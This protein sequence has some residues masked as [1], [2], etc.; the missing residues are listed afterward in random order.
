MS[1]SM[2]A[3]DSSPLNPTPMP[4]TATVTEEVET[5]TYQHDDETDTQNHNIIPAADLP[6]M[7]LT[8]TQSPKEE[9][10][11]LSSMTVLKEAEI[12]DEYEN[13]ERLSSSPNPNPNPNPNLNQIN[14]EVII[15]E[16]HNIT[17][18]TED[19]TRQII[20]A[21]QHGDIKV[22]KY[23]LEASK[24]NFHPF[25]PNTTDGDGI[26]LVHWAALN[27]KLSTMKYLVSIGA[28][29]DIPAGD[30]NATPLLWAARYGL[31]Y[32]ADWL[33]REGGADI[34]VVDKNGIGLLLASVFSSNVMMVIYSIW[35]VNDGRKDGDGGLD[36]QIVNTGLDGIDTADPMGRTA[37]HWA[38]YQGDF[39]TVDVLLKAGAKTDTADADGFTAL[40]W[41]LVN[42]SRHVVTSLLKANC[43]L[44]LKNKDGKTAW[45]VAS[46]MN[47][48]PM[49]TKMLEEAGFDSATGEK[50][51]QLLGK[52]WARLLIFALP[53]VSLPSIIYVLSTTLAI[54]AK[55]LL[56]L[57]LVILQQLT[58]KKILIPSLRRKQM[59]LMKT[60]FFAGL[61][62]STAYLCITSWMFRILPRTLNKSIL[63]F[64]LLITASAMVVCFVKL[65]TM[66][67]GYVPAKTDYKEI[68]Q[69]IFDLLELREFDSNHYCVY[70]NVRRPLRSKF[71]R[72]TKL[73]VAR[74]DHYCPWAN[75]NIGVRNHKVFFG[76][77][78]FLEVAVAAWIVLTLEYFDSIGFSD[79]GS[80]CQLLPHAL[81][82]ASNESRFMFYFFLWVVLQFFWLTILVVVQL[83]QISKGST[84][85]E[86]SR[87]HKHVA[88]ENVF[89][90]VPTDD[91]TTSVGDTEIDLDDDDYDDDDGNDITG[92]LSRNLV[93]PTNRPRRVG[94]ILR[95]VAKLFASRLCRMIG[96]DQMVILTN[97]LIQKQ[98]E[99]DLSSVFNYGV[100]TN[101]RDFLFLKR[102]GDPESLRTLIAL[103]VGGENNLNGVL[104]D[105]Y[106]LYRA[107]E[108]V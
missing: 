97:D 69:T 104:V 94:I 50:K 30:M 96:L 34:S 3:A 51:S 21:A 89:S 102:A 56:I 70:S 93:P 90:S 55:L 75:T 23:Y 66:D 52:E 72:E 80:T 31:V 12:S 87:K 17:Q 64:F 98:N 86:F 76:F 14:N 68:Q 49:W 20:S 53:Y 33:I 1:G 35:A 79:Q 15:N 29:P 106:K 57:I 11:S 67:P 4:A 24:D 22:L 25:S 39:L 77:T 61:F 71:D 60:P 100:S 16:E 99:E 10:T 58:L 18:D 28:D 54:W 32:V 27:N 73:I 13:I 84:T 41:A 78:V 42:G 9:V 65:M 6:Q 48:T 40:H 85:Y 95:V 82:S 2:F 91:I 26:T 107:P 101:W 19:I 8:Q 37:L 62:S 47:C 5:K 46:D 44:Q 83:V 108:T 105:Y 38:S 63:N 81:C 88:S 45:N 59:A 103:P 74:F 43:N 92:S 7:P 36:D